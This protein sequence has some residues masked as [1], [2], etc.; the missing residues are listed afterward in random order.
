MKR[1]EYKQDVMLGCDPE[2]FFKKKGV[3]VGS[4]KVLEEQGLINELSGMF[5]NGARKPSV[6]IDG[7]QAELNPKPDTCR[8]NLANEIHKCFIALYE[9]IKEDKDLSVV[10]A[11]SVEITEDELNSLSEKSKK[12][13]CSPSKNIERKK[14]NINV[15]PSKY[16][17][18]PA[19]GHIHLGYTSALP[20][21]VLN[22]KKLVPLLDLLLGNTAVLMDRD[23]GNIERRK[24]Y[25]RAS[26]YRTPEHG[27]EYRTLSNF[28]LKSYPLASWV[29]G[30]A[31]LCVILVEQSTKKDDYVKAFLSKVNRTDVKNAINNNDFDLAYKNFKK[32]EDLL[33]EVVGNQPGFPMQEQ[34]R[35]GFHKFIEKGIDYW[36]KDDS[37][38]HWVHLPDG[39]SGGWEW[40]MENKV[41]DDSKLIVVYGSLKKGFYN[42]DMLEG[43]AFLGEDFIY[44]AMQLAPCDKYPYLFEGYNGELRE[45]KIEI[46]RVSKNTYEYIKNMEI[47]AGYYEGI[48]R[49][50]FGDAII[51]YA[52]PKLHDTQKPYVEQ[53][54]NGIIKLIKE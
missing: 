50:N 33:Y 7:V 36:F 5:T 34:Y 44:R 39:H 13:G 3:V 51:Y 25:G 47:I 6:I 32:I 38:N 42:H 8:A 4:E 2:F 48:V 45:H 40:F 23:P 24:L 54:H 26:E 18:R 46:Y 27:L 30:M 15:D 10:F 53:F 35:T 9:K 19:G 22:P 17:N 41:M 21:G 31:R 43:E 28:W 12:F 14:H 52:D 20:D 1:I 49:T 37:F 16:L 11:P 29:W